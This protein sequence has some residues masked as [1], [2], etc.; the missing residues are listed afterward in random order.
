MGAILHQIAL[1]FPNTPRA[2]DCRTTG[3]YLFSQARSQ[4]MS[5]I[6]RI[7]TLTLLSCLVAAPAALAGKRDQHCEV[8]KDGKAVDD[9]SIKGRKE[10]KAKGGKW[11]KAHDHD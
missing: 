4:S 10:C 5:F 2:D 1:W 3:Q 8:K 9:F 11:V 6:R 7:V